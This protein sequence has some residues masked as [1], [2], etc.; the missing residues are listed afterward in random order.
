MDRLAASTSLVRPSSTYR[1][2]FHS[3]FRFKDALELVPYLHALG[4]SHCYASPILKARA[5]SKHGYDI[6]DHNSLNSEIGTEEELQS[7]VSKLKECGMG[8]VL[9]MVPN[10]MG[11]GNGDNPWWQDVLENGRS[12]QY[13]DFFDIDWE[14]V[15]TELRNKVLIPTLG[16]QYGAELE[17]GHVCLRYAEGGFFVEYYDKRFPIDAQTTPMIFEPLGDLRAYGDQL[18][19]SDRTELENILWDLRQ[20]PPHSTAESSAAEFRRK[21][22]PELRNRL[23]QIFNRS[24]GVRQIVEAAVNACNGEVGNSRSFDALHRLLEAQA[25]RLAHWRV[26]A[27]EIN[28]RRFFD[29][30][31]LVG[32]RMENPR[33]FAATHRLVRRLLADGTVSGLRL[34]HPDGLL[35]PVQ[36]FTRVQMLYAASQCCGAEPSGPLAENGIEIGVQDAFGQHEW[37][38]Q[39]APL[40][41][42]A[43]KILEE[44]E[45]LPHEWP[46]SGTVGYEFASLVNGV[47]IDSRNERFFTNLYRR[48]VGGALDVNTLIYEAKKLVMETALSSEVTVL[49]HI[50]EEI[51][52]TDR[53]ARDFTRP[54]LT[55]AIR[56]TIACFPV[57]RTYT[58]ER[59]NVSERDRKYI[60]QAV[61]RA[62]RR[63]P[64]TAT[65]L[66]D[67]LRDILLLNAPGDNTSEAYRRRLHFTLKFQQ[68]TGPVMAKGL[69]DTVCYVYN[70]FVSVNEVGG[71]PALFGLSVDEFH[72]GNVERARTWP[73][74]M[75]ATSTHDT[76]RSEDVRA[77]LDVLSEMPRSWAAQVIRWRRSNRLKKRAIA[78]GRVVPDANE[79]YLLYQTLVGAWPLEMKADADRSEFIGRMQ[80]YM[81]KAVH[82]AKVNLSWVNQ[83]PEYVEALERFIDRILRLGTPARPNHFLRLIEDF[84]PTVS[85]FGAMNS[86]SQVVLKL[87]VPGVP[88][89]YQ[90]MDLW[91]FSLVDPDN[92]RPVDYRIRRQLLEAIQPSASNGSRHDVCRDVLQ[93]YRD[94]RLKLFATMHTLRFRRDHEELF[95]SGSTY[96]PLEVTGSARDHVIAF[97]RQYAG[98][99]CLVIAPRLTY[100]LMKG[101]P[102]PPLGDVWR[103]TK[104][105][106]PY[107]RTEI[108]NLFTGETVN[109]AN[110]QILCREIF[111]D[112]PIGLLSSL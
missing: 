86:L 98:D 10:H 13:A 85:F 66:F 67:F 11:V 80:E 4:I 79:E 53:H 49:S 110:G 109:A 78:D 96:V 63:N 100:T 41:L 15:K 69:E 93:N 35:N 51:A 92:R 2:Q 36:Y 3:G 84:M 75:L 6:T 46:V 7:F 32:L 90:G 16:N 21:Q 22:I 47:L 18:P 5:G 54:S 48:F 34:D 106:I 72:A 14:P 60:E 37:M 28:Y 70:R 88:D 74:S 108:N 62:K 76:K 68:L 33:V 42:A 83:N 52:S 20:L 111:A 31:D 39:H 27:Q 9:D 45:H 24:S 87:T 23:D 97:A 82:E 71:S 104:V 38:N 50:L 99:F 101:Q 8:L 25:Y 73:Y 30:N 19:D 61:A 1:L 105:A 95:R 77:R 17:S 65:A 40:Y 56:E 44:G 57:Y 59:G 102:A 43:E 58:D 112:F 107:E 29:I 26:S 81:K 55:D 12:S 94:G 91:D 103:D 89:V 64:G